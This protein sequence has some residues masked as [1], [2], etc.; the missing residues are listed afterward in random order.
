LRLKSQYDIEIKGEK[1]QD[2]GK[3]EE[4]K[5]MNLI[6]GGVEVTEKGLR[7]EMIEADL[8]EEAIERAD[9]IILDVIMRIKEG[10]TRGK[11]DER[12]MIKMIE[13]GLE[14]IDG[15]KKRN[16]RRIQGKEVTE[17]TKNPILDLRNQKLKFQ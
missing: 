4:E 6:E 13:G 3:T 5:A 9:M 16:G 15:R 10:N 17:V 12:G 2:Q 1:G 11:I 8:H 14:E 7:G